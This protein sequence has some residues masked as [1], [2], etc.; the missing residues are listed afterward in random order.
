MPNPKPRSLR[1]RCAAFFA[2]LACAALP[3]ALY[4][5]SVDPVGDDELLIK[6]DEID[7]TPLDE[8]IKLCEIYTNLQLNFNAADTRDVKLKFV[9]AQRIKRSEF[10]AYFQAVLRGYEFIVVPYGAVT[11]PGAVNEGGSNVG[12][13]AIRKASGG[14]GAKPGYVKTQAPVVAAS[15]LER[16]R[17]DAGMV[18]TTSFPLRYI[19]AQEAVNM[20]TTY[21]SDPQ[22]E[23]VRAVTN[24]NTLVAT[25]FAQS[26]YA[27]QRLLTLIDIQPA[28]YK[29]QFGKFDLKYA[30]AEE[31][32]PLIDELIAA[33]RGEAPGGRGGQVQAAAASGLPPTLQEPTPLVKADT[34]TNS[35]F[36]IAAEKSLD[37]IGQFIR[38]LDR[39]FD[40]RGDTHVYR[41]KN[42]AAADLEEI[43][44]EWA[45]NSSSSG[46]GGGGGATAGGAAASTSGG[47]TLEQPVAVVADESSNSL[48]I[49]ASKS[50][51]AQVLEVIKRLDLRRRQV[52]IETALVEI[53]G[54][55]EDT[56]GVELGYVSVDE[57]P[58]DDTARGF[59]VSSFGLSTLQDT[60]GDGIVDFR[61]PLGL[62]PD[63]QGVPG[64]TAGIFGGKD[65]SVPLIVNALS[66]T[67]SANVLSLPSVLVN[68]NEAA[69]IRTIDERPSFTVSQGVNSDQ[70]SFNEY[71]E[72]GIQL[73]I[74][75][76][77]SA[78]N[79][80]R[81]AVKLEVSAFL[82]GNTD[83]PPRTKRELETS[84]TL[85]DGHTMVIGGI[86]RDDQRSGSDRLPWLGDLPVLGFLFRSDTDTDDRTTLYVFI[87]PHIIS[88]DF[89]TLDDL[90]YEKK[91]EMEALNGKIYLVDTDWDRNNADTRVLDAAVAG[92]FDMP[93]YASPVAGEQEPQPK[94]AA[95]RPV[96]SWPYGELDSLP[97]SEKLK[98]Q[99]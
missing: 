65:F 82:P 42:S 96:E 73:D 55:V 68:D 24:S 75:P 97:G 47:R 45:Q 89:A 85:P 72:A 46:G 93:S 95:P 74:S 31:I 78:G 51:Y 32:Q 3:P 62:E 60:D 49:T 61:L 17:Y 4:G 64:I 91:K 9:G 56:L 69:Y 5:Q 67:T 39:E 80:L 50:R 44:N 33:E 71:V 88:D 70:T 59:G 22:L 86:V 27:V 79:Y 41:L 84:V 81:L 92:V 6:F 29:P 36:V 14:V 1:S 16:F 7:G 15:E 43:L 58:D 77:I 76:S 8:F 25:G 26:L 83:P 98:S 37:R 13:F 54:G 18:L 30:V 23:G 87:T 63:S 21:L 34:R 28:E 48:I 20:L 94:A 99:P 2:V 40:P 52:L 53:S 57:T 38:E 90:S 10:W 12:F 35:L 66:R 11:A 19:N